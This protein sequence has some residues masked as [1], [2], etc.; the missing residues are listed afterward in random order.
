METESSAGVTAMERLRNS[1]AETAGLTTAKTMRGF[2]VGQSNG[3]RSIG[4]AVKF[5]ELM[6]A[7]FDVGDRRLAAVGK[8][9]GL[10]KAESEIEIARI[11][12]IANAKRDVRDSRKCRRFS[13]LA[14]TSPNWLQK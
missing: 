11:G 7:D 1:S 5:D 8:L 14:S 13:A 4:A 10:F 2:T 6:V 12:N 3:L 9:K